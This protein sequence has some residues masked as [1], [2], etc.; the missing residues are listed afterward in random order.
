MAAVAVRSIEARTRVLVIA[1]M[2]ALY[3]ALA[4]TFWF[5][6]DDAYISYR[7]AENWAAG[8]G[9][10]YNLGE[11]VPV[12]GYSNWLWMA[13]AA[14]VIRLGGAPA[15]VVPWVSILCGAALLIA[16]W[17][18]SE[19][20][21]VERRWVALLPA[22]LLA[23]SPGFV[24][25]S[26]SGLET[27]AQAL[28]T[29]LLFE[30]VALGG[31]V[32]WPVATVAG[33]SLALLRTEGIAWV[34]LIFAIAA[35][36]ASR[37]VPVRQTRQA[38]RCAVVVFGAWAL[39]YLWRYSYYQQPVSNTAVAKLGLSVESLTR[40]L[41]YDLG[42][43]AATLCPA[44][45]LL[46]LPAAVRALGSRGYALAAMA[47]AFPTYALVVGGD[48]MT[49]GRLWLPALPFL[50]LFGG[51]AVDGL[52]QRSVRLAVAAATSLLVLS[53]LALM[54]LHVVP[55]AL[56]ERLQVRFNT[57]EFR[58]ELEQWDFMRRNALRWSRVGRAL[59][60]V[61][62]PGDSIVRVSIGAI[63]FYSGLGVFDQAGLVSPEVAR[64]ESALH[65][66]DLSPGHDR[67]VQASF[68]LAENPTYLY[69][70]LVGGAA[71]LQDAEAAALRWSAE[72]D[73]KARYAPVL[74]S[75]G[76]EDSGRFLVALK[77]SHD[78]TRQWST[79]RLDLE[80][81]RRRARRFGPAAR[82]RGPR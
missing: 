46:G 75:V 70:D 61:S 39:Y 63:G 65:R 7:Y 49:M 11:H 3:L 24:I 21:F 40:G 73:V 22:G 16:V 23:L 69:A 71:A 79:F 77:Y 72:A 20:I 44:L 51:F 76:G 68:F 54:N 33:I 74:R 81:A 64:R 66:D 5:V 27:M 31:R 9:P 17:R 35:I 55:L 19:G 80:S 15:A 28:A 10:R 37:P 25:W 78:P 1:A 50:A 82:K 8:E 14:G 4:V 26:T 30:R 60:D 62:E 45:L 59:A 38:W 58:S 43:L 36:F 34:A 32:S 2:L 29:F 13:L 12:E 47:C 18:S 53:P 42:Y 52:A 56:R 67:Y 57:S 6:C 41:R 48:F